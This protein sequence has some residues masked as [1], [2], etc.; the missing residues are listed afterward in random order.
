MSSGILP[1][2]GERMV[3]GKN[4]RSGMPFI[5]GGERDGAKLGPHVGDD[6]P[7]ARGS[8]EPWRGTS[9]PV[10]DRTHAWMRLV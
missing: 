3:K 9:S 7:A 2:G 8:A 10:P 5:G 6:E 4:L 1:R